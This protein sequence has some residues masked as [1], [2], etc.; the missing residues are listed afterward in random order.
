VQVF[1][2]STYQETIVDPSIFN[3]PSSSCSESC[4]AISVCGAAKVSRYFKWK[5]QGWI[6]TMNN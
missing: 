4:S 6:I 3:L 2:P 5:G 1:D